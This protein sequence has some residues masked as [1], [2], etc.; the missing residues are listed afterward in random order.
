MRQPAITVNL[1]SVKMLDKISQPA[2]V[3]ALIVMLGFFIKR[4][5]NLLDTKIDKISENLE[6]KASKKELKECFE[7]IDKRC[8][9][10]EG[11]FLR[12]S[13]TEKGNIVLT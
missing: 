5:M 4:W 8:E 2:I 3:S 9:K 13:H 10:K 11:E 1:K 12:H 6:S 7:H